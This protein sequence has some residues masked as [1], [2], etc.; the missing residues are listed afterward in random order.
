MG[1]ALSVLKVAKEDL[2]KDEAGQE[3]CC[4]KGATA[5]DGQPRWMPYKKDEG[6][7]AIKGMEKDSRTSEVELV[8]NLSWMLSG[9]KRWRRALAQESLW[10][11]CLWTAQQDAAF[12]LSQIQSRHLPALP[13]LP[14]RRC[15]DIAGALQ[16]AQASLG[17][18]CGHWA[19]CR[20]AH[21]PGGWALAVPR[22][23]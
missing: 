17:R 3:F 19:L 2:G 8:G 16:P 20:G 1:S 18:S 5:V 9:R 23:S 10:H 21:M 14:C 4:S 15:P 13:L 6:I 12:L 22:V 11:G 7:M